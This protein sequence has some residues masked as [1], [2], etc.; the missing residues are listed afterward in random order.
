MA[1]DQATID[2]LRAFVRD[3]TFDSVSQYA[4]IGHFNSWRTKWALAQFGPRSPIG[5]LK[6]LK[7]EADEAITKP[8]DITEYADCLH[9]LLHAAQCAGFSLGELIGAAWKKLSE[10]ILREWPETVGDE[11]TEHIR[12]E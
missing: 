8:Q 1:F 6:H 4:E 10:N 2:K 12:S 3:G 7:R 5:P 11:P 9:C